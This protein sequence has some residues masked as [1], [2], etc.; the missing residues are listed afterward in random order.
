MKWEDKFTT[1]QHSAD[2]RYAA[3]EANSTQWVAYWL[4][5]FGSVDLGTAPDVE[6]A[7]VLCEA[8]A[9]RLKGESA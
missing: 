7:R 8:H 6:G 5:P 4:N 2:R 9:K 3:V 1:T